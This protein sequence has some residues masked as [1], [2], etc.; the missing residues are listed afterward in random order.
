MVELKGYCKNVCKRIVKNSSIYFSSVLLFQAP[1]KVWVDNTEDTHL[2]L[3]YSDYQQGFQFMGDTVQKD[4]YKDIKA[5]FEIVIIEFMKQKNMSIFEY[6]ADT[7]ELLEMVERIFIGKEFDKSNQLIF[8]Y[9]GYERSEKYREDYQIVPIDRH[10]FNNSYSNMDY[11][12]DEIALSNGSIES[13]LRNGFG[14][15]AIDNDKI[16]ARA[17]VNF[18]YGNMDNIGVDT[19]VDYRNKGLSTI[20]IQKVLDQIIA[21]GHIP[22]WDCDEENISSKK[23][24]EK[25]G[26]TVSHQ[27]QVCWFDI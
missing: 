4:K 21:K 13:Y 7:D 23:V 10:F 26:F 24:A 16:I 3:V 6:G 19:L 1:G 2:V 14:Y 18:R 5:F 15:A 17:M 8:E 22:L 27:E 11:I 20:L 25:C 12:I 9:K